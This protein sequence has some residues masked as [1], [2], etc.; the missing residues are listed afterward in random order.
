MLQP[1]STEARKLRPPSAARAVPGPLGVLLVAA[2]LLTGC[3]RNESRPQRPQHI[4]LISLDTLRADHLGCYGNAT[5]RTP[6]L[7]ALA[8][9]GVVFDDVTA[10]APT[11]LASHASLFAGTWP[12]RTGVVRN[13]YVVHPENEMLAE[14]LR[15]GDYRTAGFVSSFALTGLVN[16]DQGFEVWDE[17]FEEHI[18]PQDP[19]PNQR[20]AASVTN[21]VLAWLDAEQADGSKGAE[22][23]TLLFAHYFDAHHPY[24][25]PAPYDTLYQPVDPELTGDL[26]DQRRAVAAH[27]EAILGADSGLD[28]VIVDGLLRELV[29][30]ADGEPRGIDRALAA[31]YAGEVTYLDSE[32]GRLFDGLRERGVWDDALVI[33]TADHGETF[34]EHGDYWNHGLGLYQTTVQLPLIV[35]LPAAQSRGVAESGPPERVAEPVAQIDIMPTILELCALPLP[36]AVQGQSFAAALAGESIAGRASYTEATQPSRSVEKRGLRWLGACKAKAVR[37]GRYKFVSTPYLGLEE[38]YALD[39]DP[40]ERVNLMLSGDPAALVEAARLRER[41]AAWSQA[42]DPYP[43]MFYAGLRIDQGSGDEGQVDKLSQDDYLR[44]LQDLGYLG[45]AGPS[46]NAHCDG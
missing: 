32:L 46:E 37:D 11:T 41:L 14:V 34:W 20:R 24:E 7:D 18:R 3:A 6:S 35:K 25:P 29:L 22:Q 43:T 40:G 16:I 44:K 45:E 9:E 33:V 23:P 26:A 12:N 17:R 31:R 5:V 28:N 4:V 21:A 8:R 19:E 27:H 38:L 1:D 39:V 36:A 30:E 10:A 2:L 42:A 13:G 15:A